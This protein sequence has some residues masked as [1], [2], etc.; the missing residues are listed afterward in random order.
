TREAAR[1]AAD[2]GIT[3]G[4]EF[5]RGTLTDTVDSTEWL[6]DAVGES[7]VTTYWQ[8]PLD[9]PVERAVAGLTRLRERVCALH[10]FSWWPF[11]TR[12][13]L[14]ERADLW[15]RVFAVV[16]DTGR[17]LDALLEFVPE[18]D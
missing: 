4:F 12:L 11:D 6:L 10:V 16:A 7:N 8:P 3:I 2:H 1:M 15:Q 17:P 5:H 9:E 14:R 18:D 13:P